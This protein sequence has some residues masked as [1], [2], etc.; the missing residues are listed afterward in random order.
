MDK[1]LNLWGD[2]GS[3]GGEEMGVLNA[4]LAAYKREDYLVHELVLHAQGERRPLPTAQILYV[5]TPAYGDGLVE[6][7]LLHGAGMLYLVHD[8]DIDFLPESR[9]GAHARRVGL[10]HGLLHLV[11]VGVYD[12]RSA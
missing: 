2:E 10:T 9:H 4:K 1:L 5:M 3:G 6:E 12:E 11:R 8:A 7:L